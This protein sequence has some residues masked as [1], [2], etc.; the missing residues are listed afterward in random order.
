MVLV[1]GGSGVSIQLHV[2]FMTSEELSSG[3]GSVGTAGDEA[4]PPPSCGRELAKE[5]YS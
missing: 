3:G 4:F 2:G 5:G 1:G